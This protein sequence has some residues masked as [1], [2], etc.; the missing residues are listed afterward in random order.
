MRRWIFLI[1]GVSRLGAQQPQIIQG[2]NLYNRAEE[3]ALNTALV[4]RVKRHAMLFDD[5]AV[6]EYITRIG[7]SLSTGLPHITWKPEFVPILTDP[8]GRAH[9]PLAARV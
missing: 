5:I 1:V 2:I 9:E 6:S 4:D 7:N 8:R 3:V